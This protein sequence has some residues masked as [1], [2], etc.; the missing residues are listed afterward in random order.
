MNLQSTGTRFLRAFAVV[1]LFVISIST[2]FADQLSLTYIDAN[3]D[4]QTLIVDC[5]SSTA[6]LALAADLI[7][8]IGV[9]VSNDDSSGAC[10]LADIAAAMA[11]AA[12]A[13]A[14][15]IAQALATLSPQDSDAIVAAVNA[16]PGVDSVA[17]LAAVHFGQPDR[18]VRPPTE[19]GA[20]KTLSLSLPV[21]E[22]KPSNN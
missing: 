7:D 11:T 4:A 9:G 16:V 15:G 17:V 19:E 12:P 2:T 22:Q 20:G 5:N 10:S 13:F 18:I 3:S 8:E 1:F 14:A 6:D 21:I